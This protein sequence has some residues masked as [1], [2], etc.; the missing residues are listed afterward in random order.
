[1]KSLSVPEKHQK[2]IALKTLRMP[3]AMVGVMGG[4]DKEQAREFLKEIGYTDAQ[5]RR[6]EARQ[7]DCRIAVAQGL[8]IRPDKMGSHMNVFAVLCLHPAQWRLST[9]RLLPPG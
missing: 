5:V 3:D 2:N 9:A 1:M 6:L 7:I 4:M 8:K